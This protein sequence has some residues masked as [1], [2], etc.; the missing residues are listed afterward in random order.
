MRKS[1][2]LVVTKINNDIILTSLHQ[3][4]SCCCPPRFLASLANH[5]VPQRASSAWGVGYLERDQAGGLDPGLRWPG[6]VQVVS[7]QSRP[8]TSLDWGGHRR[9]VC[10][11]EG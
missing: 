7:S 2:T 4:D 11:A 9:P 3:T 10:V 6:S 8:H 1:P 5:S